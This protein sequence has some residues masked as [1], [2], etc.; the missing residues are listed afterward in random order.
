MFDNI[1]GLIPPTRPT[2][3]LWAIEEDTFTPEECRTIIAMM[4]DAPH[5]EAG[6]VDNLADTTIRKTAIHWLPEGP[7]T[8][9]IYHRLTRLVA[10]ANRDHFGYALDGFLEEAQIA[11]YET[12]HFYDWHIDRGGKGTASRARKLTISVQLSSPQSYKG[13]DLQL[14]PDGHVLTAPRAPGTG[15]IFS[16]AVLHRVAPII[17]GTRH[18]LVIWTH[19]PDFV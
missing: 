2:Q 3:K 6:L 9:W 10:N 18:S 19:G 7:S 15:V 11:R 17:T 4:E 5:K 16:A 14:N 8:D 1:P 13:G 12:G